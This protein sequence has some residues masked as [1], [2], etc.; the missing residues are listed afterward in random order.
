ML[1]K[2]FSLLLGIIGVTAT[3]VTSPTPP[4][5][6]KPETQILITTVLEK[7]TTDGNSGD[8]KTKTLLPV[9]KT[10]PKK[11]ST[12]QETKS[13]EQK[14]SSRLIIE[15]TK[16]IEALK[17]ATTSDLKTY[18]LKNLQNNSPTQVDWSAINQK[19]RRAIVNILCTSRSGGSFEPLSGSGVI[20]DE[21]GIILTTAHIAQFLLIQNSQGKSLLNCIARTGSP[22][23]S[24]YTLK[25]LYISPEWLKD[26]YKNITNQH[27]TGTG[28]NDFALLEIA[29]STNP[30]IVLKKTFDAI[31]VDENED[32]IKAGNTVILVGY[33]AG[34][35]GGIAIQRDLYIVSSVINIGQLFTFKNGTLDIFNLGGSP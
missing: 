35:L 2:I 28:E 34:F 17:M 31:T 3:T 6:A 19:A 26:N 4:A 22:A 10:Q 21:R 1:A 13:P 25:V 12:A 30:D 7:K 5:P 16:S 24:A 9:A 32:N 15:S 27:P 11:P 29:S 23:I 8:N 20:I 14:K 18:Q 33:P